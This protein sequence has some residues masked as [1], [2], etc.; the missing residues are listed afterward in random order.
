ISAGRIT[1]ALSTGTAQLTNAVLGLTLTSP[2]QDP[3]LAVSGALTMIGSASHIDLTNFQSG[4]YPVLT[5]GSITGGPSN[6]G[7]VTFQGQPLGGRQKAE[8]DFQAS[9]LTLDV[10]SGD[11]AVLRWTGLNTNIWDYSGQNWADTALGSWDQFLD[12]D[13][14]IFDNSGTYDINV[15]SFVKVSGMEINDGI[16][17][18][19]GHDIASNDE[20]PEGTA[21]TRTSKLVVQNTAQASFAS[22]AVFLEGLEIGPQAQVRLLDGGSFGGMA[23]VND[24]LLEIDR[25]ESYA[26]SALMS[27]S[28]TL[29]KTGTGALLLTGD[30]SG[31]TASAQLRHDEGPLTLES[32]WAGSYSQAAGTSLAAGSGVTLGQAEFRGAVNPSGI[33]TV[34][35]NASFDSAQLYLAPAENDQISAGS[36]TFSGSNILTVEAASLAP[37]QKTVLSSAAALPAGSLDYWILTPLNLPRVTAEL[38]ASP[39]GQSL[40]LNS[41]FSNMVLSW[42]GSAG[43]VW[44]LATP[45]WQGG[46]TFVPGDQAVFDGLG[47]GEVILGNEINTGR[48]EVRSGDYRFAGPNRLLGRTGSL[49]GSDGSLVVSGGRLD[50][51]NQGAEFQGDAVIR[52]GTL[53]LNTDLQ[54]QS[55]LVLERAGKLVFSGTLDNNVPDLPMVRAVQMELNGILEAEIYSLVQAVSGQPSEVTVGTASASLT[56]NPAQAAGSRT[57]YDY[58]FAA[59]DQDL[60]LTVTPKSDSTLTGLGS[61]PNIRQAGRVLDWG[62]RNGV[63]VTGTLETLLLRAF[64]SATPAEAAGILQGLDSTPL[65]GTLSAA[66][67]VII[68]NRSSLAKLLGLEPA[69]VFL[70]PASAGSAPQDGW[71][72]QAAISGRRGSLDGEAGGIGADL[73]NYSA[74]LAAERRFEMVRLGAAVQAG[75]SEIDWD[76]PSETDTSDISG[77]L[78]G[79]LDYGGWFGLVQGYAGKSQAESR[80][81]PLPGLTARADF[82][83]KWAGLGLTLGRLFNVSGWRLTPRAGASYTKFRNDGIRERG[84]GTLN[85]AVKGQS[86][87]SLEL[88]SGLFVTRDVDAGGYILKPH[89]NLGVGLETQETTL[90]METRFADV[91]GL[92][93]FTA[94][95]PETGR[96]RGMVELGTELVFTENMGWF[97]SYQGDFKKNERLHSGSLGFNVSF[98]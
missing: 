87:E 61:S 56:F 83:T 55:R 63:P 43:Q 50:L 62:L 71:N 38:A 60:T 81:Q 64:N 10:S 74:Q 34:T 17:N 21:V 67:N 98:N 42:T 73:K 23:M 9:S 90:S 47:T 53:V 54:T 8:M 84:A 51:Q 24:G 33:L 92:P 66:Q 16:Y 14:V 40:I 25:T 57:F 30:L 69:G 85:Q 58:S 15:A 79:R 76:G 95:S 3:L 59:R 29:A 22:R 48:L 78:Y 82:D 18:F 6:F 97:V 5:F 44:D 39:D 19:S 2:T 49:A 46:E 68:Y 72:V 27:G 75:Q 65:A 28:G 77:T 12:L 88:E 35:G 7:P 20:E 70:Y 1:G 89:L 93:S 86:W 11:N 45:S 32:S 4:S 13:Y 96:W 80:R 94:R 41:V 31:V 37:G 52:G 91:P 26:L 36:L